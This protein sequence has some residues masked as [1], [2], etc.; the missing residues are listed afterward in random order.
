MLNYSM[1]TRLMLQLNI[2][3]D[4]SDVSKSMFNCYLRQSVR[5]HNNSFSGRNMADDFWTNNV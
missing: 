5:K 1:S 4:T 2:D 3:L